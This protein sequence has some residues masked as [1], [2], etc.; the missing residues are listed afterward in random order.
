MHE[1]MFTLYNL[2]DTDLHSNDQ[3]LQLIKPLRAFILGSVLTC[4]LSVWIDLS[5]DHQY[6]SITPVLVVIVGFCARRSFIN[7]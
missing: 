3:T 4:C 6:H 1:N 2:R 7:A 5:F